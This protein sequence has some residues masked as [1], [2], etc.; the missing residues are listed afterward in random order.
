MDTE[1]TRSHIDAFWGD[2]ILPTLVTCV[3]IPAQ[4]LVFDPDW[5]TKGYTKEAVTMAYDWVVAQDLPGSN[6]HG[7]N[8]SLHIGMGK[9]V[10][11]SAVHLLH[12]FQERVC[13]DR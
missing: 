2:E 11:L 9:G 10:T 8:E 4:S 7:P 3:A 5:E 6:A 1:R 13:E 12:R